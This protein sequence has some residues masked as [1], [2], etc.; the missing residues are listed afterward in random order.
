MKI[1]IYRRHECSQ[2]EGL[3]VVI[4][5]LRAFTT[6]AY[7]FATGAKEIILVA[8]IEEALKMHRQD[9][10]LI[11]MGEE[12]GRLIP[13][14][15][16]G[17][18]PEEIRKANLKDRR[19][20]QRTS[21]GTQGVVACSHAN[22]LMIASFVVAEATLKRILEHSP[23]QV[24]LIVTGTINGDEDLALAEYLKHRLLQNDISIDPFLE[25][26]KLSP[27]GQAFI[28]PRIPEFP[29]LDLELALQANAFDFCMEVHKNNS[30]LVAQKR[31]MLN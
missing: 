2:A 30:H 18:S 4:D 24:S 3:C 12:H 6:A 20:V 29:Q 15:H 31:P 16:Y 7:A 13:G 9:Q 27:E 11:L 5:V 1:N 22:Q 8:S 26:V 21:A 23:S 25:R 14:F 28:D 10:T 19:I 17:N